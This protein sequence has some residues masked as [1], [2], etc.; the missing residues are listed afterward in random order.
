[1]TTLAT[2]HHP[3]AL[4]QERYRIG[5]SYTQSAELQHGAVVFRIAHG[6]HA[7]RLYRKLTQRSGKPALSMPRGTIR[8]SLRL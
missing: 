2:S 5:H 8:K 3:R 7:I 4:F 6:S 1:M